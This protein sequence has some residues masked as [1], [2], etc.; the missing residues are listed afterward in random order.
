MLDYCHIMNPALSKHQ[1]SMYS[2]TWRKW[3]SECGITLS[4]HFDDTSGTHSPH[5]PK[6]F[7]T[8]NVDM[9]SPLLSAVVTQVFAT[10]M[11]LANAEH[12]RVE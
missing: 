7:V 11:A 9:Y 3:E 12:Y 4:I 10:L 5:I 6:I 8:W 1:W 2:S